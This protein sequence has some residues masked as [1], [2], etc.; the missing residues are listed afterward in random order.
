VNGNMTKKTVVDDL[1]IVGCV[2]STRSDPAAIAEVREACGE[3]AGSIDSD[4]PVGILFVLNGE[5]DFR[6]FGQNLPN[7][8]T[9][10]GV[11]TQSG[12][13]VA[14]YVAWDTT[15]ETQRSLLDDDVVVPSS[16]EGLLAM[17]DT[18]RVVGSAPLC[19]RREEGFNFL[20]IRFKSSDLADLMVSRKDNITG[21][22]DEV[23]ADV[24]A[25]PAL[26]LA[27]WLV[28]H[29]ADIPLERGGEIYRQAP[30]GMNLR[31]FLQ[32]CVLAASELGVIESSKSHLA[33]LKD[34]DMPF[35]R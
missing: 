19:V 30:D 24:N 12:A 15:V 8:A 1:P 20:V 13:R 32:I 23:L 11:M 10:I 17:W 4:R 25:Y 3:E 27:A 35:T 31:W 16:S 22:V 28:T 2:G 26:D 21:S 29:I 14:G 18:L 33:A 5:R 9:P 34:G 7:G 6:L